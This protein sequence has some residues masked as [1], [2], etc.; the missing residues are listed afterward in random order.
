MALYAEALTRSVASDLPINILHHVDQC[1]KC[2]GT[3]IETFSLIDEGSFSTFDLPNQANGT[4]PSREHTFSIVYRAAA[5][6]L[7]G[8]SL[9]SLV[10]V[11][12]SSQQ[13]IHPPHIFEPQLKDA[14][15]QK[16]KIISPNASASDRSDIEHSFAY[17]PTLENLVNSVA[18]SPMIKIISPKNGSNVDRS[19]K[20]IWQSTQKGPYTIKILSNREKTIYNATSLN[21]QWTFNEKL[22]PG[23]YYWKLEN[24]EDLLFVGKFFVK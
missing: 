22:E 15:T 4:R 12:E 3:I 1:V 19:I 5:V 7:V 10:Y 14:T 20:F 24:K 18:R 11:F 16:E 23:L 9:G 13:D 21:S 2:K 17:S 6:I 8:I